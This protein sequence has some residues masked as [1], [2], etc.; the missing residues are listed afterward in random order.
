MT[1][2]S[3]D[4]FKIDP[5]RAVTGDDQDCKFKL[6]RRQLSVGLLAALGGCLVGGTAQAFSRR[7][8]FDFAAAS[9]ILGP[10][11]VRVI[12]D[13]SSGHDVLTF[14]TV[15]LPTIEYSQTI[16]TL[17]RT[18][19]LTPSAKTSFFEGVEQLSL[20]DPDTGGTEP[21]YQT[22]REAGNIVGTHFHFDPDTGA[23]IPCIK[24]TIEG[25]SLATHELFDADQGGIQ[26]CIKVASEML[27]GGHIG[28]VD[29]T[30]LHFS[31]DIGGVIPC[32]KTTIESHTLATHELF[33][34]D[35]GGIV[36]CVKVA[37]EML[38]GAHIGTVDFTHL[39]PTEKGMQPSFE[40]TIEDHSLG[41]L[42]LFDAGWLYPPDPG[43]PSLKLSAAMREGVIG[44]VELSVNRLDQ[45]LVVYVGSHTYRLV[46]GAL[47]DEAVPR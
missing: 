3:P 27:E 33:D 37:S 26:P 2:P 32:V 36:P 11:G 22:L 15:P 16:G 6:T 13:D 40:A 18:G 21:V 31:A 17:A 35:Q 28:T 1:Y 7:A 12:G 34:A 4:N 24:T 44:A 19:I 14:E 43:T 42:Q 10:Y 9:R 46:D 5:L 30:H 20:Y 38:E 29:F 47:V 39:Q 8:G 23:I 25:Q 45:D 41:T